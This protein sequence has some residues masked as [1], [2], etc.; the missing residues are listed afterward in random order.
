MSNGEKTPMGLL[1]AVLVGI[2]FV[3]SIVKLLMLIL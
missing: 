3:I 1:I 2:G